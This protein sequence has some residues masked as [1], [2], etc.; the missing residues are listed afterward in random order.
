MA[1]GKRTSVSLP[2]GVDESA[3]ATK[4]ERGTGPTVQWTSSGAVD[5]QRYSGRAVV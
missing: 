4:G 3:P 2:A 1:L 5:V